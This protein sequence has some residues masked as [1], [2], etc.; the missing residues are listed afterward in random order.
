MRTSAKASRSTP[1]A[2]G[3][4]AGGLE[5]SLDHRAARGHEDDLHARRAVGRLGVRGDLMVEHSLVEAA[6]RSPRPPGSARRRRAASRPRCAEARPRGRR[7]ADSPL[8]GGRSSAVRPPSTK[9]FS[10]SARPSRSTTSPSRTRP[11]G[12]SRLAPRSDAT[13]LDLGGCEVAPVDIQPDGATRG[14]LTEGETHGRTQGVS[15]VRWTPLTSVRKC[16]G[17]LDAS[18]TQP[19]C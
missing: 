10:A 11:S 18:W 14:V 8:R 7:S 19:R 12:S 15:A 13:A 6:S 9:F 3:R 2:S 17:M 4:P 16:P 1:P 5:D